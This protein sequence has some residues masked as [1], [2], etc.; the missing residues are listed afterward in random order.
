M[1]TYLTLL[2]ELRSTLCVGAC[3]LLAA[4]SQTAAVDPPT[5]ATHRDGCDNEDND[6]SDDE[7]ACVEIDAVGETFEP[8]A[9]DEPRDRPRNKQ[10]RSPVRCGCPRI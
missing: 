9:H 3:L 7:R 5:L 8:A 10:T 4:T 2:H 6:A 1:R